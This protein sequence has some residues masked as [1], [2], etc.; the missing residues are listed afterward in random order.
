MRS[1]RRLKGLYRKELGLGERTEDGELQTVGHDPCKP[2]PSHSPSAP[3][4]DL[5]MPRYD[6]VYEKE[7]KITLKFWKTGGLFP[8]TTEEK[9]IKPKNRTFSLRTDNVARCGTK[10]VDLVNTSTSLGCISYKS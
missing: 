1:I 2:V 5:Q 8:K 7:A 10:D 9:P 3:S 4:P 6:Y